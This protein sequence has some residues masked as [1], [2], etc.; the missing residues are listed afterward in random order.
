MKADTPC[1][2]ALD[3][4]AI[5]RLDLGTYVHNKLHLCDLRIVSSVTCLRTRARTWVPTVTVTVTS[6]EVKRGSFP[7]KTFRSISRFFV[8]FPH[9]DHF[10]PEPQS[11]RALAAIRAAMNSATPLLPRPHGRQPGPPPRRVRTRHTHLVPGRARRFR[12]SEV[13]AAPVPKAH[14]AA[15]TFKYPNV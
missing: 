2:R 9:F 5:L 7:V 4:R 1:A 15:P 11:K 8:V 14:G 12:H 6:I 3:S 10:R 13:Y